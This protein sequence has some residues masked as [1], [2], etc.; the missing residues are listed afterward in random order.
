MDTTWTPRRPRWHAL[1]VRGPSVTGFSFDAVDANAYE[2][3]RPGYSKH[4]VAWLINAAMR[5]HDGLVAD[6]A[7]GTGKLTRMLADGGVAAVAVE[8]SASMRTV[9]RSMTRAPV[10]AAIAEALPL[11]NSTLTC[12]CVAQAFHHLH[13]ARAIPELHRVLAPG[14]YL[15]LV[16]NVYQDTDPLKQ[17]MDRIIDRYI[18]PRWPAA[19]FGDWHAA[20]DRTPLFEHRGSR[21]FEHPHRLPT[22]DLATLLLTSADVASLPSEVQRAFAREIDALAATL[23]SEAVMLAFTR[24]E[25]FQRR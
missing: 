24:V 21:S 13:S 10:I 3:L 19:V 9:L 4:A 20:L 22:N 6:V 2:R 17:A 14:A 7:A 8:P 5:V 12:V 18:D 11:A 1:A 16:W 25:L 23:P 15:A